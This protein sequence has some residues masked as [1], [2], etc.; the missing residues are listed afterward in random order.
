MSVPNQRIIKVQKAKAD[1]EHLYTM[2]N[3]KALNSAFQCLNSIGGIKL[4]IY[5]G[6]NQNNYSF[7]LSRAA[8]M[9][10]SGLAET[11]YKSGI[12]ELINKGYLV[13]TNGNNYIFYESKE[14]DNKADKNKDIRI[15]REEIEDVFD[16]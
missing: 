2:F 7:E 5:I 11:A 1:K 10:W 3:L 12:K 4:F 6:K 13:N 8:F 16:F 15:K 9:E 14:I